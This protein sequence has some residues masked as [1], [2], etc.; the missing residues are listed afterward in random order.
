MRKLDLKFGD[1]EGPNLFREKKVDELVPQLLK[2][3]FCLG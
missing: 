2:I 1:G 3:Y